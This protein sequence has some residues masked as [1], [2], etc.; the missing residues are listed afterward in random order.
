[1]TGERFPGFP[2]RLSYLPVPTS[3]FGALLRDIDDLDEL[4]VTL[5]CWRLLQQQK[6][7]PRFLRH[8]AL[9]ADRAL[10]QLVARPEPGQAGDTLE[11]ALA[12]IVERGTLLRIAV[13][14]DGQRDVCYLL[15]TPSNRRFIQQLEAGQAHLG[16][17]AP[18]RR[19]GP[20]PALPRPGI[21]ELYEQNVGLL[22]PLIAEEL[23]EA[24][25]E[26]PAEWIED[27]FREAVA[28]NKRNW[29]YIRRI[30]DNW[31]ARGRGERG[32]NR[33]YPKP[34]EDAGKY[35][36]GRYGRLLKR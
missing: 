15:N 20:P 18:V 9:R 24:E 4:K 7:Q 25:L 2:D 30:L 29:R 23:R 34:P 13:E 21:Y 22:T 28:Y 5:H 31:A 6:G 12:A 36:Q 26:F 35:L 11:V 8:A 16:P 1:V 3:F 17:L 32:E 33:G 19:S 10:R 27:A 14:A